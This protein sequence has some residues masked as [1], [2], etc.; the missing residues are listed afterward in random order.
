M[1]NIS[2]VPRLCF[3]LALLATAGLSL[4]PSLAQI[5]QQLNGPVNEG[6]ADAPEPVYTTSRLD[7]VVLNS[8]D[9]KP[10]PRVLVTSP[11]RRMA[12]ITDSDGRVSFDFRRT[13]PQTSHQEYSTYPPTPALSAAATIPVTLHVQKPGYIGNDVVLHIAATQPDGPEPALQLKIM[14]AASLTGH[15]DPESGDL[16]QYTVVQLA[17][18][19]IYNG[20]RNWG[21]STAQVNSR[22]EFR[23]ANLSPGDYKL[24]VPASIPLNQS[25]QRPDSV[26]GFRPTFYSNASSFDSAAIIHL[27]PGETASVSLNYR[28]APCYSVTIPVEGPAEDK[29]FY[30]AIL[31]PDLP[32]LALSRAGNA[33]QGYLPSGSYDIQLRYEEPSTRQNQLPATSI[34][35]VHLQIDDK[36][37]RTQ[38][39]A[40]HP[41]FEVPVEVHAEFT[42]TTPPQFDP[43][44]P[45]PLAFVGLQSVIPAGLNPVAQNRPD[46]ATVIQN[47]FEGLFRVDIFSAIGGYVASA[48]SGTTDLLREPLRVLPGI[49]PRPIEVIL[50]DDSATINGHLAPAANLQPQA[51]SD[52]PVFIVCIP[53]D[54]PQA[55]AIS[56]E[57]QRDEFSIPNLAPG[58]YLVLAS[59]WAM[60]QGK[61][62][63]GGIEYRDENVLRDLLNKGA[64]ITLSPNQKSDLEVPLLPE[65]S[66]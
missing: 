15:L 1:Q 29:G 40:F 7:A 4:H 28:N 10:V 44:N 9:G 56:L 2:P 49:P 66:N 42:S 26:P 34:A 36:A 65:D 61:Q 50:R 24:L 33:I 8:L 37:V 53:L 18:K 11:D 17:R 21:F 31:I 23:F 5:Q 64:V 60:T 63:N 30:Y 38:P 62:V 51:S 35:S 45:S 14:P 16:P 57:E 25:Q 52:Q 19:N 13:V 47:L 41:T 48:T 12:A 59:R 27:G 20:T 3:Q 43:H 55:Q 54:R 22:G 39:V 32:G 46:G 58:R 6:A